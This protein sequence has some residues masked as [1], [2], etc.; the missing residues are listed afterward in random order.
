MAKEKETTK[1]EAKKVV[2]EPTY[3]VEEFTTTPNVLGCASSD[4]VRAALSLDGKGL[5]TVTEAKN[6]VNKFKN[7]EVK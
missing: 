2:T 7:K 4:I 6:I 5:Y 1:Q 3:T